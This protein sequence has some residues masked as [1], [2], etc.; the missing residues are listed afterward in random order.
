MLSEVN[1]EMIT[2]GNSVWYCSKCKA[3][4]GLCSGDVLIG[5]KAIK[6]NRCDIWIHKECSYI[7]KTLYI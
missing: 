3:D 2:Y 6:C 1:L 7:S 4:C 5:Y